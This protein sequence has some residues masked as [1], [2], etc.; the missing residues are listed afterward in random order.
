MSLHFASSKIGFLEVNS[1]QSAVVDTVEDAVPTNTVSDK[2]KP[3][4]YQLQLALAPRELM[5]ISSE[6]AKKPTGIIKNGD[7]DKTDDEA[8]VKPVLPVNIEP[9]QKEVQQDIVDMYTKSLQEFTESLFKIKLALD[10]DSPTHQR[11]QAPPSRR[12]RVLAPV[13]STVVEPSSEA[14]RSS[15]VW[16]QK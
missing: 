8:V 12:Q 10:I 7:L 9:E 11:T 6:E 14:R 16:H 5:M 2:M 4:L 13:C 1:I 15:I 3:L